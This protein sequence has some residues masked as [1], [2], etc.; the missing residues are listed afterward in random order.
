MIMITGLA[1]FSIKA[2]LVLKEN[3][4]GNRGGMRSR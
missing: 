1:G 3:R 4:V 2:V